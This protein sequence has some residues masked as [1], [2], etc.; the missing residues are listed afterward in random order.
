VSPEIPTARSRELR[1][2]LLRHRRSVLA[3]DLV[4]ASALRPEDDEIL[5][6]AI[7]V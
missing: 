4:E 3:A 1:E 5:T 7:A 6:D 2:L